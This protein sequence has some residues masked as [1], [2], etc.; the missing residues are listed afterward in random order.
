MSFREVREDYTRINK[1][2]DPIESKLKDI[3][4]AVLRAKV[5]ELE[6]EL[7]K[8]VESQPVPSFQPFQAPKLPNYSAALAGTSPKLPPAL[9]QLA[10][11]FK[12]FDDL[13]KEFSKSFK[14]FDDLAREFS[15]SFK[16]F[17]DLA[18]EFSKSFKPFDDLA[19]EL[20]KPFKPS[21]GVSA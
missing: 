21:P 3:E 20:S 13:A 7:E 12:P 1:S 16:P 14:P 4:I 18:K 8:A 9:S 15:K 10:K 2:M 17:D 6:G 5:A 19:R 11:S